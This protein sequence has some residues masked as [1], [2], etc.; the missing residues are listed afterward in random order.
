MASLAKGLAVLGAFN[1]RQPSMSLTEAAAVAGLSRAA[2][3]RVLLTLAELGYVEQTGRNFSLAP[4]VLELGFAYLSIQSWIERAEPLMR[5]LSSEFQETSTAAT[6]HGGEI[7]FVARVPAASRLV[8]PTLPVGS[9]LPA[10][11]T[12]LGRILLGYLSE[13]EIWRRLRANP[14]V[15]HTASTIVDPAALVERVMADRKQGFSIVDEELE[16]DLRAL[17]VPILNRAGSPVGAINLAAHAS[18]TTRNEMREL[19]LPRLRD[20]ARRISEGTAA[21]PLPTYA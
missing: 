6:L 7:V 16:P 8:S 1:E 3:R 12:S 9:R 21:P 2:A 13:D 4:R 10:F 17:A 15:P 5:Q 11:H 14:I 19:F 18:R 20:V